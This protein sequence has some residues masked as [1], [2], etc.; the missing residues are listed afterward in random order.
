MK[1]LII[2]FYIVLVMALVLGSVEIQAEI[3]TLIERDMNT[4]PPQILEWYD[5]DVISGEK[6]SSLFLENKD[7]WNLPQN[8]G[9]DWIILDKIDVGLLTG[10]QIQK[11]QNWIFSGVNVCVT[12]PEKLASILP[13]VFRVRVVELTRDYDSYLNEEHI[14]NS[15]VIPEEFH[16]YYEY[17]VL[18]PSDVKSI[19][20]SRDEK[21]R[22]AL[23]G[24]L[25]YGKGNIYFSSLNSVGSPTYSLTRFHLNLQQWLAG[26]ETP[27]LTLE[28]LKRGIVLARI[29]L[30]D[31][32]VRFGKVSSPT[33]TH[34]TFKDRY[35]HIVMSWK[36]V[37]WMEIKDES[38]TSR[39]PEEFLHI[40]KKGVR[41]S[42]NVDRL[43][44]RISQQ[45]K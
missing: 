14:V 26:K 11:L 28:D 45:I 17:A 19:M 13:A 32:K 23:A 18:Q 3:P 1:K 42:L 4:I 7:T 12:A 10:L 39:I 27:I 43:R 37:E 41:K 34:F 29:G 21:F 20:V 31:G 25:H 44:A 30:K 36:N 16:V 33:R 15:D 35:R 24:I 2:F 38:F 40:L 5:P 9:V 22:E 6:P 8:P